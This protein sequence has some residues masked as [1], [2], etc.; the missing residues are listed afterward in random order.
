MATG[1]NGLTAISVAKECGIL[2]NREAIYLG[3]LDKK[4]KKVAWRNIHHD[5]EQLEVISL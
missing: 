4:K 3:E 2:S 1:D 5:S